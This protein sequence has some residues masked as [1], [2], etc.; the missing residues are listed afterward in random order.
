MHLY[1]L[2]LGVVAKV[3]NW[4]AFIIMGA[5]CLQNLY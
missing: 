2:V 3:F 5:M 4:V 1:L